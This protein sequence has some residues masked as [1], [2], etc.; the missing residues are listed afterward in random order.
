M[1]AVV[2]TVVSQVSVEQVVVREFKEATRHRSRGS[3]SGVHRVL[4]LIRKC[5][6]VSSVGTARQ[7]WA[8]VARSGEE[9]G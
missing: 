3:S 8:T 9:K 2:E 6:D 1:Q 5:C 4:R 7:A